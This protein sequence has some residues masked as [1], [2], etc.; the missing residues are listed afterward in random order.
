MN[1]TAIVQVD[2]GLNVK[3]VTPIQTMLKT[4]KGKQ[5]T[6]FLFIYFFPLAKLLKPAQQRLANIFLQIEYC[7]LIV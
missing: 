1:T 6:L 4:I 3:R 2:L 7:W 5:F